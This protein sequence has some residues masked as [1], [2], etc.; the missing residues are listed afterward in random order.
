MNT[1]EPRSGVEAGRGKAAAPG[2]AEW[3]C[4]AA[5]PSFAVMALLTELLGSGTPDALCLATQEASPLSGMA[6][7]Y[8][9]MSVFH[10]APWFR[11]LPK[12]VVQD[13]REEKA[14]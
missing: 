5:T 9:L 14:S 1:R 7:M 2:A 12:R 11:F 8:L 10:S 4:L 13:S 3:L 6:T